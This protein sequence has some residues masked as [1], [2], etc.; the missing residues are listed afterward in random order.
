ML[1]FPVTLKSIGDGA[2]LG[3]RKLSEISLPPALTNIGWSAFEDCSQICKVDVPS[4]VKVIP[5]NA[6]AGCV[7]LSQVNIQGGVTT[8]IND[9]F[10]GC[11]SIESISIPKTVSNISP[12]SFYKCVNLL[13]IDVADDNLLYK[14]INGTLFTKDVSEMVICPEG[15]NSVTM[16]SSVTRLSAMYDSSLL[17]KEHRGFWSVDTVYVEQGDALR[18]RD[19]IVRSCLNPDVYYVEGVEPY[20]FFVVMFDPVGGTAGWTQGEV[21]KGAAVGTL[22]T[23]T[24]EGYEFL[25]WF[26]AAVGGMQ[27]TPEMVV[28]GDVTFYAQWQKVGGPEEPV[29]P[30]APPTVA[31]EAETHVDVAKG[32]VAPFADAAAVYDGFLYD[33]EKV[34][35]SVQVKVAKM[36]NGEAKVTATVQMAGQAKKIS[37]KSG[38]AD[39][40]GKVTEMTDKNGNKL[41]VT[42]GVKGLG[43]GF[44]E[45]ALPAVTYRIDGARNV[46]SG[47]SAADKDAAGEAV[48]LYKGVY[49]VALDGGTL[50][51]SVDK[52]GK[53]K[54][55]GT[56]EGNKVSATSQLVVGKDAAVVPVVIT[57]KVNVAFC[58]WVMANG[59]VEARGIEGAIADRPSTLKAGAKFVLDVAAAKGLAALPG[60]YGEYLPNGLGVAANGTKWIVAG[61]VKAGKVAFVKGGNTVDESKLGANPSGLKLTYKQKDGTFK[62]SFKVYNL[63]SNGKIK[64]YTA[65]VTGVM[66]GAKGYGT[67]TVK[68]PAC[69]FPIAVE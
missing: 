59:T 44:I 12:W 35:G 46:F 36:K 6:F 1:D 62:G 56:V 13:A 30:N 8:I 40:T 47:K 22:P 49:N 24:W 23:A 50:S 66:I 60:L 64:A 20:A 45:A 61:G 41:A 19:L 55:A 34:A 57:K 11:E 65:N 37:F 58:L 5:Y 4:G 31:D 16:P 43:G 17:L 21:A 15:R 32:E 51:V 38:V 2:F 42:V 39:A 54:I 48:R 18:V 29:N 27:V 68:K 7:G 10:N 52:K 9:A 63:E 53:A 25:G 33:G 69:T 26:T 3:C 28:T 67:A 14:S